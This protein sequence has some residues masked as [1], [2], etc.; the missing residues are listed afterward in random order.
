MSKVNIKQLR[1]KMKI[2]AFIAIIILIFSANLQAQK[3]TG[4]LKYCAGQDISLQGF[5]GFKTVPLSQTKINANGSFALNYP[6]SYKGMAILQTADGNKVSIVLNEPNIVMNG[7]DLYQLD[8]LQINSPENK[9]YAKFS[10]EHTQRNAALAGWKY[11][12][13]QYQNVEILKQQTKHIDFIKAEINRIEQ[14]DKNFL[15]SVDKNTYIAYYLPLR[16]F[17]DDMSLSINSYPEQI[18]AL[19]QEF[20]KIDFT[21]EKLQQSGQLANLIQGH[22]FMLENSG[23]TLD[24][25][26]VQ[27][28]LST[29][30]IIENLNEQNELLNNISNMLFDYMEQRSLFKSSEHLALSLL[31]N[32]SCNLHKDL[33][34][35]LETYRAMKV[36]N[37]ANEMFFTDTLLFN[38]NYTEQNTLTQIAG[39]HTLIL[40][41]ASECKKCYDEMPKIIEMYPLLQQKNV[42]VLFVSL[43]TEKQKYKQF[44]KNM[45]WFTYCDYNMWDSKIVQDYY[46]FSTPSMFL[47]DENKKIVVRPNSVAHLKAWV[48]QKIITN[49]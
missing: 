41:G 32:N 3:L 37:T 16:K 8:S 18:P 2:T 28:N 48:E 47:L 14:E 38:S 22:Y 5:V 24:S 4:K 15:Q 43:D 9:T 49:E 6:V 12:L 34:D 31:T 42:E 45:P 17:I 27:M 7:L 23:L 26:F 1:K 29:N 46:V 39:K 33:S 13:P 11:L 30:Y 19:I 44:I 40:F 10:K 35:Q 21:E 36:G 20:R 25:M